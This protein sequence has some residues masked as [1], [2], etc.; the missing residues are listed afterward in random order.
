M[1]E[2]KY[3]LKSEQIRKA[4]GVKLCIMSPFVAIES[5]KKCTMHG[6]WSKQNHT[7]TG[8]GCFFF[9]EVRVYVANICSTSARTDTISNTILANIYI[10]VAL[11]TIVISC[12]DYESYPQ[13]LCKR[14]KTKSR[15]VLRF[16]RLSM[17]KRTYIG[18]EFDCKTNGM[19]GVLKMIKV[20]KPNISRKYY[21]E[22]ESYLKWL[23]YVLNRRKGPSS[24]PHPHN[25]GHVGQ[26]RVAGNLMP[27]QMFCWWIVYDVGCVK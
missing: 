13:I 18:P 19:N 22:N 8:L 2:V 15:W 24:P 21:V 23:Y 5:E 17:K 16:A 27:W 10:F 3:I 14:N 7:I 26:C 11:N 9:G 20:L 4:V 1:R 12:C 25:G 6:W